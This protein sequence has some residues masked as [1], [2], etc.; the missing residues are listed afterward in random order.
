MRGAAPS[1]GITTSITVQTFPA[2]P[3]VTVFEYN[4]NM[5]PSEAANAISAFQQFAKTNIPKEYGSHFVLGRGNALGELAFGLV[6]GWYGPADKFNST[7]APFLAKVR[8]PDTTKFTIGSYI[9]SVEYLGGLGT[10]NTSAPDTTDTFYA[11][12]LVTPEA[13]PISGKAL[14]AFTKYLANAENN[15]VNLFSNMSRPLSHCIERTGLS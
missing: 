4:W 13:S 3:S 7:I 6:G 11:K 8:Q 1:F 9:N 12:S 14:N 2:P 15:L 5:K 10:L